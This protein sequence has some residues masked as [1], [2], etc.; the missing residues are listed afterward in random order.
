AAGQTLSRVQVRR[1][2]QRRGRRLGAVMILHVDMDAFYASVEERDNPRLVGQPVVVGGT[3]EGRGVVAAANY[4]ARKFGIH[5][6]MPAVT[7]RR[8]CPQA[9]FLPVR[10]DH[11]AGISHQIRDI[12]EQY[13][14]L[15]E[16]LSLDEAFLDVTGSQDLFG[17]APEIGREIKQRIR[18]EVQLVASVGVATNKF[19]AKIASDLQKPDALV[20]VDS[21]RVQEFLDPLP[22]GR[23]WGIGKV[24][25]KLFDRLGI[26]TI[27]QLRELSIETLEELFGAVGEHY[28][29]LAR[30]VDE[31]RVVPDREAKSIS[32]ETTFAIDVD[33]IEVLRAWLLELVEQVA[34]RLRRHQLK[35]RTVDLKV[36]FAD[37]RTISRTVTLSEPTNITQEL[38]QAGVELLVTRLPP[39]HLPVRLLGMGVS[40]FASNASQGLLFEAE[41]RQRQRQLDETADRIQ[42]R[43]GAAALGRAS[44]LAHNAYHKPKPSLDK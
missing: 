36:R 8:L 31:R 4:V 13:T 3:A 43:F 30:G 6:A 11:Y 41:E 37:F 25:S 22:V 21:D 44:G 35:G 19:L 27:G 26:H 2:S 12:F 42:Q 16:P 38:W 9:M 28:W 17:S 5:S 24:T 23:I 29:R 14:P 10:M 33:D 39:R 15:V 1:R 32:H 34:R 40:G 7:A 18:D 20:V